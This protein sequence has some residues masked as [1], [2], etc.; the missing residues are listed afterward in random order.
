MMYTRLFYTIFKI[1]IKSSILIGVILLIKNIFGEKL[2]ARNQSFLWFLLIIRLILPNINLKFFNIFSKLNPYNSILKPHYI[3]TKAEVINWFNNG[4][5][6][7]DFNISKDLIKSNFIPFAF[8]YLLP[9]IWILGM[10]ILILYMTISNIKFRYLINNTKI[11]IGKDIQHI[12]SESKKRLNVNTQLKAYKSPFVYSPCIYGLFKPYILLPQNIE[13]KIDVEELKYVLAHELAHFKRKDI[14]TY[15]LIHILQIIYWFNPIIWYGLFRMKND[16]EIACDALALSSFERDEKEDYGLC[17]IHLLEKN[18]PKLNSII[19]TEFINTKKYI[20]RRII[21]IK[22]FKEGSYKISFLAILG[23]VLI[24]GIFL[25]NEGIEVVAKPAGKMSD[26]IEEEVKV[27]EMLWPVPEYTRISSTFGKKIHP[28]SN[29]EITHT[30]IDIPAPEGVN[31]VAAAN[32]KVVFAEF[33]DGY[34]KTV[35]IDHGNGLATLYAHCSELLVKENDEV[36]S[37]T[38]IAKIGTT[39]KSTGPHLHFEVRKDGEVVQPLDYY[40]DY[41]NNK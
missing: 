1:S 41:T 21:M 34:G 26:V 4:F 28:V 35:I 27:K 18:R 2:G 12:L 38:E 31:I 15:I 7:Q 20:K 3:L 16:C 13:E 22:K 36:T 23:F 37:G 6:P 32:G 40:M 30:G 24:A 39:G 10:L 17:I 5:N 14:F 11:D 9:N 25:N 19:T 29:E 8:K 33:E